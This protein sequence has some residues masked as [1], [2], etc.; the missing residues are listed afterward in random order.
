MATGAG[1]I[2]TGAPSRSER[3]AK[4]NRLL[5]IEAELGS[6][7]RLPGSLGAR[8]R[9]PVT[10]RRPLTIRGRRRRRRRPGRF[11][12]KGAVF[13]GYVGIG[14]ALVIAIAF[15]LIIPVQTLVFLAAPI[16]GLLI[17]GYANHGPTAGGRCGGC[18][19][20]PPGRRS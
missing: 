4:Y 17:G 5:R 19:P 6:R 1:Q 15:A 7:R 9:Q 10:Q 3:V 12:D 8:D 16:A 20:T 2:K 18:S 11:I 13:A 14:M